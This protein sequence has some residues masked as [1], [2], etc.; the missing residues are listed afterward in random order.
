[1]PSREVGSEYIVHDVH[2]SC[3][4]SDAETGDSPRI[5]LPGQ[6]N[7]TPNAAPDATWTP[8][9]AEH[10]E[11]TTTAARH[12][13][14]RAWLRAVTWLI[15][16]DLHPK[17][18]ATTLRVAEDLAE[19]M[20]YSTGHVL[21]GLAR[22]ALRLRISPATLKRHA[23]YLRQLGALAW[24]SHGTQRNSR[25][26]RG[27]DGYQPT[28]TVYA[29]TIPADFDDAMGHTVI[30][31]G[32]EARIVIDQRGQTPVDNSGAGT[33]REPLSLTGV[34]EVGQ[35]QMVGGVTTTGKPVAN[36]STTIPQ[37]ASNKNRRKRTTILGASVTATGM[38][39][40]DKL[41]STLRTAL[42]W[43]RRASHDEL[44][45]VCA[46]MGERRW[47]AQQAIN[48]ASDAAYVTRGAGHLW[49]PDQPHRIL[50]AYLRKREQR[51]LADQQH[52]AGT[53]PMDN[54]AWEAIW[55]SMSQPESTHR[56]ADGYTDEDRD[57]ARQYGWGDFD[58]VA[59]DYASDRDDAIDLYGTRLVL[60]ALNQ[61]RQE[62]YA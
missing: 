39:L 58:M 16:A 41:A 2:T 19:R 56:P 5:S 35:V 17:A 45:W 59:A 49:Q 18:N 52:A 15:N 7:Q 14:P 24:V 21:Y 48:F 25:A 54:T 51:H 8:V 30:G 12:A 9:L 27:L 6:R 26:A 44:R 34:K 3:Q 38:Q 32:Y 20:D 50:A 1:M 29:A 33:G 10:Q 13:Q 22:M 36:R 60:A 37:Q 43:L 4:L 53:T 47:T 31:D 28:A 11:L 40:G 61:T 23:G 46:D 42:P 62:V 55:P 57:M